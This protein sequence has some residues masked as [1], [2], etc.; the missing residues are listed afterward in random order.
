MVRA[1][2]FICLKFERKDYCLGFCPV[3]MH[4]IKK[5]FRNCTEY[6]PFTHDDYDHVVRWYKKAAS[7]AND[8]Y[9]AVKKY[10]QEIQK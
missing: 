5:P 2:C 1:F 9:Q 4:K 6:R 8:R 10:Y 3:K 7:L